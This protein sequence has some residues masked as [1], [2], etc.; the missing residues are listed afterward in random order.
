MALEFDA[1]EIRKI[2]FEPV[3]QQ[4]SISPDSMYRE[5]LDKNNFRKVHVD[6]E[7]DTIYWEN[8]I[9]LDPNVLYDMSVPMNQVN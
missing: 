5:L 7:L 6:S 8:G 9:D 4:W 2:D 3:L 1:G